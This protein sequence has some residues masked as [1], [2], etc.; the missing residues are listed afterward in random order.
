MA[1]V[2][3]P[4]QTCEA[5]TFQGGGVGRGGARHSCVVAFASSLVTHGK[6]L[7]RNRAAPIGISVT[8]SSGAA[9]RAGL[10]CSV[11]ASPKR[12]SC[13]S[14]ILRAWVLMRIGTA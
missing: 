14:E 10:G 7:M 12:S 3:S 2:V 1:S 4:D 5:E 11:L 13:H 9:E 6:A 8:V